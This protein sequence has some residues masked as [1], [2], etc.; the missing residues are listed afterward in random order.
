ME[1]LTDKPNGSIFEEERDSDGVRLRWRSP[2]AGLG[3]Y[4]I[5]AA[6]ALV[7]CV[8]VAGCFTAAAAALF[9][10]ASLFSCG[11]IVVLCVLAYAGACLACIVW[12][13]LCPDRP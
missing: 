13:M 8:W 4:A 2:A 6:Y 3:H 7:F 11:T 9:Q 12:F 1:K 5:A 10:P